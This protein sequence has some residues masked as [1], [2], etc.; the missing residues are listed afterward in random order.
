MNEEQLIEEEKKLTYPGNMLFNP[1]TL[2]PYSEETI[3]RFKL[4]PKTMPEIL[5]GGSSLLDIGCNK[6]LMCFKLADKYDKIIGIEHMQEYYNIAEETRKLH[7]FNNIY[8]F[9]EDFRHLYF[10]RSLSKRPLQ[11]EDETDDKLL[12]G[13]GY[14]VVYIGGVHHHFYKDA[15]NCKAS[16]I[17]HAK[18]LSALTN[19]YLILDGPF[20]CE[21][22]TVR[23]FAKDFNWSEKDKNEFSLDFYKKYLAPEFE[24]IRFSP[25]EKNRHTAVFKRVKTTIIPSITKQEV[26]KIP[27]NERKKLECN[28]LRPEWTVFE[29]KG[30]RYK[31]DK[32]PQSIGIYNLMNALPH[33]FPKTVKLIMDGDKIV[34]DVVEFVKGNQIGD[35]KEF[36][37]NWLE[38]NNDLSQAG[39]IEVHYK[40]VDFLRTEDGKIL[41][42]D[43]DMIR[44]IKNIDTLDEKYKIKWLKA[45]KEQCQENVYKVLA[46]VINNLD[47]LLV[48]RKALDSIK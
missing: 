26:E 42:I 43:V 38:L 30:L 44:H 25:N 35:E 45:R 19:K 23:G 16:R 12:F 46:H 33:R 11:E 5:E 27:I 6:G 1:V 14:D 29:H 24:L 7:K 34:G 8:F 20:D 21:Y 39:L 13:E 9:H 36:L 28:K 47:D 48:F 3:K 10:D 37:I 22:H 18:K 41:D 2:E 4:M 31:F 17:V 15:I 32:S 40:T